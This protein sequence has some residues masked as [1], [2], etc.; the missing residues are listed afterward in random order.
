MIFVKFEQPK[1]TYSNTN[2]NPLGIKL[3]TYASMT[4]F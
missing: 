3:E 2:L 1:Q 4:L